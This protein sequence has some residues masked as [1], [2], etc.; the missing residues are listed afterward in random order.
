[1]IPSSDAQFYLESRQDIYPYQQLIG[2]TIAVVLYPDVEKKEAGT[3]DGTG[4]AHAY[5]CSVGSPA[6]DSDGTN[7]SK[8]SF[9][10]GSCQ[11]ILRFSASTN[12]KLIA[13]FNESTSTLSANTIDRNVQLLQEILGNVKIIPEY[14]VTETCIDNRL[15]ENIEKYATC[16]IQHAT[17]CTLQNTA[18]ENQNEIKGCVFSLSVNDDEVGTM[19]TM[20]PN[21]IPTPLLSIR[22]VQTD[23]RK[24]SSE[25]DSKRSPLD[26]LLQQ[27]LKRLLVNNLVVC[28]ISD[29]D[30]DFTGSPSKLSIDAG[31]NNNPV[32]HINGNNRSLVSLSVPS[33]SGSEECFAYKVCDVIPHFKTSRNRRQS[34]SN[35]FIILPSTRITLIHVAKE[36]ND[37]ATLAVHPS[38][39]GL[40]Q[41]PSTMDLILNTINSIRHFSL[42]RSKGPKTDSYSVDIPRAFLISGPPG[43]GKT[44]SVRMAVDATNAQKGSTK[45]RLISIRGSEIL[46]SGATEADAALEL[47]KQFFGAVEFASKCPENISVIFMDECDALLSSDVAGATLGALLD[48]MSS[49]IHK[50]KEV[51][52][53][54]LD[55]AGWKRVIV[56][57]ATNRIDVIPSSLRRPGRID[58][59]LSI[60]P[61]NTKERLTILKSLLHEIENVRAQN[62][63]QP[64][65]IS[66]HELS[67]IAELCV[68][69]V[70]SDLASLIRRAAFLST[71]EDN[72]CI[73][74]S[75]FR[76]AMKDVGASA[77][78]DSAINAPPSTRWNDIAGDAGGAKVSFVI[79]ATAYSTAVFIILAHR[80]F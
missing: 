20:E 45:T 28:P 29:R 78:R 52:S 6:T 11:L 63:S 54:R 35:I 61:P 2:K 25:D 64:D 47:K 68:G 10:S 67:E 37:P 9:M 55:P 53:N 49:S 75:F 79:F 33:L 5:I 14:Y 66:E 15:Q 17:Y 69:Y 7:R 41:K 39:A 24:I 18:P 36:I 73:N 74:Y 1:M 80:S 44:Y 16:K 65:C 57:A 59:E 27:C 50:E 72:T 8:P 70:A 26:T 3:V 13:E 48:K 38:R 76:D 22:L 31:S 43:T 40:L 58:R 21:P 42:L 30:D 62:V 32:N 71:K 56:I 51:V 77:L 23:G 46:S 34:T 12:V 60:S 4:T 19:Y